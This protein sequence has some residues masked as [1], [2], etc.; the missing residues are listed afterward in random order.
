MQ[1]SQNHLRWVVNVSRNC[2]APIKINR[3]LPQAVLTKL[4]S[5]CRVN[6]RK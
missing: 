4:I 2:A 3:P 6:L 1:I 5:D